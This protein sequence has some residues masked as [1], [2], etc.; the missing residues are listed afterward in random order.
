M[1]RHELPDVQWER[2]QPLIAPRKRLGRSPPD[3]RRMLNGMLWINR[4]GAPWRDL[5]ERYGP[6][7][8]VYFWFSRWSK[9]GTFD[10]ILSALQSELDAAGR[11]DWELFCIDG[12]VVR[13]SRAAAGAPKKSA[14][15]S[16]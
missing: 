14:K 5:P 1:H 16:R 2:V 7:Q 4:T 11:I 3:P 6:W 9:D 13:A 12:T 10:R 15:G 8:T